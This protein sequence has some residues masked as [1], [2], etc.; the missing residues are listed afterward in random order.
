M[1]LPYFRFVF[2]ASGSDD[3][4]INVIFHI[5]KMNDNIKEKKEK[6]LFLGRKDGRVH[7]I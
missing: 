7:G 2:F 4:E 6:G 5:F 3:D 1:D